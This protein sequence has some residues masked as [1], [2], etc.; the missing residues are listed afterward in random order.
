MAFSIR[1]QNKTDRLKYFIMF[2]VIADAGI[3]F[4]VGNTW[5]L[6]IFAFLSVIFLVRKENF[7]PFI[8]KFLFAFI[9]LMT[10]QILL[11]QTFL[12]GPFLGIIL[13]IIYA[14]MAIKLIGPNFLKYY[15]NVMY[16]LTIISLVLWYLFAYVPGV[17][18]I[19]GQI[20]QSFVKPISI[21][22]LETRQNIILY[23][24]DY[25]LLDKLPRNAG[26]F[27]EPGAF[28]VF[29]VIG[30]LFNT[31]VNQKLFNKKNYIF[32]IALITTFSLGAYTSLFIFL[33][34]YTFL[35]LKFKPSTFLLSLIIL[36]IAFYAYNSFDF[37]GNKMVTSFEKS[38]SFDSNLSYEDLTYRVGRNE[39]AI[40]DLN[41][42]I[43]NPFFGEGQFIKY[44]YGAS[45]SGLTAFLR[46]WGIFGFI[47]VFGS[48]LKSFKTYSRIAG[49][50]KRYAYLSVITLITIALT[51]PLYGKPLFLAFSFIF[52]VFNYKR[53][54]M[55]R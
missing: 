11:T 5:L 19:G 54:P 55:I 8:I 40:L 28:G 46:K 52:L 53:T 32:I 18:E 21:Y 31:I 4:F 13:R 26:P 10:M 3:P 38:K 17:Y 16:V 27:W 45:A 23:T 47:L 14:Y 44:E 12:A 24:N 39:Q 36:L 20:Y 1:N 41:S 49:I 30:I 34:I 15:I 35:I 25:W 37:L 51:Q 6:I 22:S 33:Y 42:F 48:M 50:K 7:N 9:A 29:L 2:I 43:Q